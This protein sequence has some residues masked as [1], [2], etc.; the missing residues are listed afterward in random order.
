MPSHSCYT[1]CF[2]STEDPV[3]DTQVEDHFSAP[4]N[5]HDA[6]SD[7]TPTSI[8]DGPDFSAIAQAVQFTFQ[9]ESHLS[10]QSNST[11]AGS[12]VATFE[13]LPPI[14]QETASVQIVAPMMPSSHI[15]VPCSLPSGGSL[16]NQSGI[17]AGGREDG[18][19]GATSNLPLTVSE[20]IPLEVSASEPPSQLGRTFGTFAFPTVSTSRTT[21][22]SHMQQVQSLSNQNLSLHAIPLQA[23]NQTT[24][25]LSAAAQTIQTAINPAQVVTSTTNMP[26]FPTAIQ[27]PLTHPITNLPAPGNPTGIPLLP[28]MPSVYPYPYP[29]SMPGAQNLPSQPITSTMFR[30]N[31]PGFPPQTLVPGY[32]SYVQPSLYGST[33][34]VN[35]SNFSR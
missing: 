12:A 31:A 8:E 6:V 19:V 34:Q 23:I 22:L 1:F 33:P 17:E 14:S 5:P 32:P 18:S 35:A 25:P 10:Q 28:T 27:M 26:N 4:E 24:A 21:T 9:P 29:A 15:D 3:E 13:G 7:S 2:Y 20:P 11:A 30:V 16:S